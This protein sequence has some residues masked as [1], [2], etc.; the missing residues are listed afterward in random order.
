MIPLSWG[1]VG[2]S[3]DKLNKFFTAYRGNQFK[4]RSSG[5]VLDSPARYTVEESVRYVGGSQLFFTRA[6]K[7]FS[8]E[9]VDESSQEREEE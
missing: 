5:Y 4:I 8:L 2:E 1:R 9:H 3:T 6:H 7:D